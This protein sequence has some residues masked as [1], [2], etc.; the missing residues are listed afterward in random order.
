MSRPL[1]KFKLH[2]G[3]SDTIK[4][5]RPFHFFVSVITSNNFFCLE[6]CWFFSIFLTH[7]KYSILPLFMHDFLFLVYFAITEKVFVFI[8]VWH[9]TITFY[10]SFVFI[11]IEIKNC[12][13]FLCIYQI[14]YCIGFYKNC[15][16]SY[17]QFVDLQPGSTLPHIDLI[18]FIFLCWTW[19]WNFCLVTCVNDIFH[20]LLFISISHFT[21]KYFNIYKITWFLVN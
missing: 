18:F 9:F 12:T 14:F 19:W 3:N 13:N 7:I 11:G 21:I 17:Y 1:F 5:N 4:C 20:L 10:L 6:G 2:T 8:Y 16:L 15:D